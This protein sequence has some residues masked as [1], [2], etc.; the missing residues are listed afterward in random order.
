MCFFSISLF[1][2]LSVSVRLIQCLFVMALAIEYGY[3]TCPSSQHTHIYTHKQNY[4]YLCPLT[5]E[6]LY[7]LNP[8]NLFHS[9]KSVYFSFSNVWMK[10]CCCCIHSV[11]VWA[12]LYFLPCYIQLCLWQHLK[13]TLKSVIGIHTNSTKTFLKTSATIT[14]NTVSP[15]RWIQKKVSFWFIVQCRFVAYFRWSK[16]AGVNLIFA[17]RVEEKLV[18]DYKGSNKCLILL[19]SP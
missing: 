15:A 1:I 19:N 16:V 6:W 8:T 7:T 2:Q 17:S 11:S 3:Q 4:C 12:A 9:A 10:C 13:E 14:L 5:A 18:C